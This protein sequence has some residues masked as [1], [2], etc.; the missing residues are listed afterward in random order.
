MKC[1]SCGREL[2][3]IDD[4]LSEDCGGDCWG[5]VGEIEALG[6]FEPSLTR[7][8]EEFKLGLRPSWIDP[9]PA[10]DEA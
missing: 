1:R 2:D 4:P 6:G 7:V 8:R 9:A 3:K 10:G 5:C